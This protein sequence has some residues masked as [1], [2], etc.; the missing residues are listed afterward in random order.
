MPAPESRRTLVQFTIDAL[1]AQGLLLGLRVMESCD[2][3]V[4]KAALRRI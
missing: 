2:A 1:T 4:E 3:D